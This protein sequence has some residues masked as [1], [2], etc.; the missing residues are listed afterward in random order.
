MIAQVVFNFVLFC[1]EYI[2]NMSL[3][4]AFVL[5]GLIEP[6]KSFRISVAWISTS[7]AM[8]GQGEQGPGWKAMADWNLG[9]QANNH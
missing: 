5:G 7:G 4:L 2:S 3:P 6:W 8:N 9:S 1:K